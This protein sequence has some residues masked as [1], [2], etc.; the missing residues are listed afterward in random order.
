MV[1]WVLLAA[2]LPV[3]SWATSLKSMAQ[4]VIMAEVTTVEAAGVESGDSVE[5][6]LVR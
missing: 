1:S 5:S 2:L 6:D 3:T 4:E